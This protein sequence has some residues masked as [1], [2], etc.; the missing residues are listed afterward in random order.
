MSDSE[1]NEKPSVDAQLAA[2]QTEYIANLYD[3]VLPVL[4]LWQDYIASNYSPELLR[5]VYRKMHAIAGTSSILNV[6]PIDS[7][8]NEVQI[9]IQSVLQAADID[10]ALIAEIAMIL[11]EILDVAKSGD[12]SAPPINLNA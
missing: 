2:L 8:S 9:K 6:K 5:D 7:L 12:I 4:S 3:R 10:A 11:N 1:L